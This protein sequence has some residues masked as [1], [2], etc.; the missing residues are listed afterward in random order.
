MLNLATLP[1]DISITDEAS[2]LSFAKKKMQI[3]SPN[4]R[5]NYCVARAHAA[6]ATY[7]S[8]VSRESVAQIVAYNTC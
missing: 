8:K 6:Y 7:S 4:I 3:V 5:Y 2:R 1:H